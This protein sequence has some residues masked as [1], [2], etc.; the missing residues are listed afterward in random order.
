MHQREVERREMLKPEIKRRR[1]QIEAMEEAMRK[2]DE[3][4]EK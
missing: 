4:Y 1:E 2:A 3:D